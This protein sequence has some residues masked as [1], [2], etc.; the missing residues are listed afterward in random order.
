MLDFILGKDIAS[1]V[2]RHRKLVVCSLVLTA[3]SSLF[4]VVLAYLLQPFVDEGIVASGTR[5]ELLSSNGRFRQL[6]DMHI[7]T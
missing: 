3:I 5:E 2:K 7:R 1:Y 4:V 6:H